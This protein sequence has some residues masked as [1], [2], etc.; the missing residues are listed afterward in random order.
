MANPDA[1]SDPRFDSSLVTDVRAYF[2][3]GDIGTKLLGVLQQ[4]ELFEKEA[5]READ[6]GDLLLGAAMVGFRTVHLG[7]LKDWL[8]LKQE[9]TTDGNAATTPAAAATAAAAAAADSSPA[10]GGGSGVDG[11]YGMSAMVASS[12]RKNSSSRVDRMSISNRSSVDS[13]FGMGGGG[14]GR[15]NRMSMSNQTSSASTLGGATLAQLVSRRFHGNDP[16]TLLA[17]LNE[18]CLV[19]EE[20]ELAWAGEG[21]VEAAKQ[22]GRLN[23]VQVHLLMQWCSQVVNK[24]K[25]TPSFSSSS[26]SFARIFWSFYMNPMCC[27]PS[28]WAF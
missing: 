26:C 25:S 20:E 9:E 7:K 13:N 19:Y 2:G 8:R 6:R 23:L 12:V 16:A 5:L 15:K 24:I 21:V 10:G 28:R 22:C 17:F 14:N 1:A 18:D 3:E 27:A 11:N 4:K